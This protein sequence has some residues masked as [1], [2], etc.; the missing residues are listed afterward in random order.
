M[1]KAARPLPGRVESTRRSGQTRGPRLELTGSFADN[2]A[3]AWRRKMDRQVGVSEK[4]SL[5]SAGGLS[6]VSIADELAGDSYRQ[7][8][9]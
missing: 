9:S 3:G 5:A 1:G 2:A 4:V 6:Y 7:R 8:L